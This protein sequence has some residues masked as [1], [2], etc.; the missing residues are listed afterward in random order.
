MLPLPLRSATSIQ[1]LGT[2]TIKQLAFRRKENKKLVRLLLAVTAM[3]ATCVLPCHCIALWVEFGSG[4]SSPYI[5][6][7]SVGSFFILYV[8]SALDPILYNVFSS[9]FRREFKK[10]W[11]SVYFLLFSSAK[12]KND[13]RRATNQTLLKN[14]GNDQ[15]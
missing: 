3:F 6:D 9:T 1:N 8:N 10:R 2:L 4:I 13:G 12:R 14:L 11:L 7:L 15:L 5:E